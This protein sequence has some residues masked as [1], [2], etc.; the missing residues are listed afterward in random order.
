MTRVAFSLLIKFGDL[1]EDFVSLVDQVNY[2]NQ[3]ENTNDTDPKSN[4]DIN[5]LLNIL[6]EL[7]QFAQIRNKWEEASK[8][9]KWIQ[10]KKS[11]LQL[12]YEKDVRD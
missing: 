11:K 9:R 10:D 1:L 2:F 5:Q 8:M 12:K 7:P 6:K 4:I 3:F